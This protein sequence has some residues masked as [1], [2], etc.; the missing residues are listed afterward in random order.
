M[1]AGVDVVRLT[2]DALPEIRKEIERRAADILD[3]DVPA[4]RRVVLVPLHDVAEI[5]NAAGGQRLD[6]PGADGVDA[7]AVLADF[8]LVKALSV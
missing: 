7:D 5:A 2:G 3:R 1:I 8:N 4:Q 6:R